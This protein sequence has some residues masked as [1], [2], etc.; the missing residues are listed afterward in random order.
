METTR[1]ICQNLLAIE[2]RR[3]VAIENVEPVVD[4]GRFAIKRVVGDRIV[5]TAD[6][7]ADGHDVVRAV[8]L[9]RKSDSEIWLESPMSDLGNDRWQGEFVVNEVGRYQY[10]VRGWV[11]AFETWHRDLR[12]RIAAGQ[13]IAIDLVIGSQLVG[14]AARL[15][16]GDDAD[17]LEHWQ[18][19]LEAAAETPS[20]E[21]LDS[22]E[23]VELM[24][25]NPDR[26][27]ASQSSELEVVVD[28]VRARFSAW[29]EMFPRSAANRPDHHGTLTDVL[30]WL[31]RLAEMGFDVL[32]LPPIHP[33]GQKF[34]KGK[35]QR[36]D[37]RAG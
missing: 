27:L 37:G 24:R 30:A 34:R 31:P 9:T 36:R 7:L 19:A 20:H 23:L 6:V 1:W 2:G 16:G 28:R 32:Y 5:V 26:Q 18:A 22:P 13:D 25:R 14:Q 17:R 12:K 35:Q 10:A 15:A 8:L 33:I 4:C 21:A 29:Y 3:R 11:D